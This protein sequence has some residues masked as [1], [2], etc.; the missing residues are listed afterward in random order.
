M[1]VHRDKIRAAATHQKT[2]KEEKFYFKKM[3]IHELNK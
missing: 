3:N 2:K 1:S